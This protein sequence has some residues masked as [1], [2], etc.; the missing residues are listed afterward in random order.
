MKLM[1]RTIQIIIEHGYFIIMH[2]EIILASASVKT[3]EVKPRMEI[4]CFI[5]KIYS[6]SSV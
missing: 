4:N 1:K 5:L 6:N 2:E 3:D